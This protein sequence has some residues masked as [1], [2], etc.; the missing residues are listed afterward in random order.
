MSWLGD[1]AL[2]SLLFGLGNNGMWLRGRERDQLDTV[3]VVIRDL[4]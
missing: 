4:V 2:T 3:R 1:E